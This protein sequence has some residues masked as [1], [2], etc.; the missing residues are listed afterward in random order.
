L[1]ATTTNPPSAARSFTIGFAIAL[2]TGIAAAVILAPCAAWALAAAGLRLPFPRIFDRTVMA[3]LLAALLLWSRALGFNCLI[4]RGFAAPRAN[5]GRA[6]LG[7][8]LGLGAIAILFTAAIVMRHAA[9]PLEAGSL[10]ARIAKNLI[11]AIA[12]GIIEEGF[13]RA[14]LL[15]GM[16]R[17]FGRRTALVASAFI[18]ALAHLVRAPAH[19]YLAGFHPMA[20]LA[21]LG[22]SAAQLAHPL[23]AAPT[24]IGLTLLGLVLGQAF[25]A[26]GNVYFSIGMHAGFVLGAK[27]WPAIAHGAAAAPRWLAGAGPVPLIA[28]PAAWL[29]AI[30]LL[31]ALPRILRA[32]P[33]APPAQADF[34]GG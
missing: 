26:T 4:R 18:Y 23:A 8:A 12:I 16:L 30:V 28:A 6:A 2:A 32:R 1:I 3:T 24:L 15:G 10:V 25:I 20:G 7:L 5:P 9:H 17:E 31:L 19:F 22:Q 29:I 14:F 34:L 21:D 13:F 27:S 33:D 11:P